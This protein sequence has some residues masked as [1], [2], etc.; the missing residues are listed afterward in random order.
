MTPLC[1]LIQKGVGGIFLIF[2]VVYQ[3][4]HETYNA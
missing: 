1:L 2:H 3:T 4:L